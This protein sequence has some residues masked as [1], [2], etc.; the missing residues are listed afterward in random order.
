MLH[1]YITTV[2][3]VYQLRYDIFCLAW[4]TRDRHFV[5]QL[6]VTTSCRLVYCTDKQD[7]KIIIG[8]TYFEH[9]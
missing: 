3:A 6:P 2:T 5:Q 1:F 4:E 8:L 7:S 9:L